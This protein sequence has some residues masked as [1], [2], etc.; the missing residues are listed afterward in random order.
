MKDRDQQERRIDSEREAPM[1][2]RDFTKSAVAGGVFLQV[3]DDD[4]WDSWLPDWLGDDEVSG[5][6]FLDTNGDVIADDVDRVRLSPSLTAAV[7][8]D[9][10]ADL[11]LQSPTNSH[12]IVWVPPSANGGGIQNA[13]ADDTTVRLYPNATYEVNQTISAT[14]LDNCQLVGGGP[15]TVLDNQQTDGSD[16]IALDHSGDAGQLDIGVQDLRITGTGSDGHGISVS[17]HEF[18]AAQGYLK[19]QIERVRVDGVGGVGINLFRVWQGVISNCRVR[20]SG[21]GIV[22]DTSHDTDIVESFANNC[23]QYGIQVLASGSAITIESTIIG[24]T[25]EDNETNVYFGGSAT[26]SEGS[27]DNGVVYQCEMVG[28]DHDAATQSSVVVDSGTHDISINGGTCQTGNTSGTTGQGAVE[29]RSEGT[30]RIS[31]LTARWYYATGVYVGGPGRCLISDCLFE[32]TGD[33][34]ETGVRFAGGAGGKVEGC[35]SHYNANSGI[36]VDVSDVVVA[37]NV[38]YNNGHAGTGRAGIWINGGEDCSVSGNRCYDDQ[39]TQTQ[40]HGI[41]QD[42]DYN[43]YIGNTLRGNADGAFGGSV[44]TNSSTA[45]NIT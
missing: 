22:V 26:Y 32:G 4:S 44:G 14:D 7:S 13:L 25:Y 23:S 43:V 5:L 28:V 29:V 6:A 3:F 17:G 31:D 18:T 42:G 1:T 24:G 19:P 40:N 33:R 45:N 21:D 30:T 36:Q 20:N 15:S 12:N 39:G 27:T 34:A 35:E 9:D 10:D 2:R 11:T 38:C 37:D 8:D 41:R 16:C